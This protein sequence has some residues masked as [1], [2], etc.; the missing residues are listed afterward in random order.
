MAR[1]SGHYEAWEAHDGEEWWE[2]LSEMAHLTEES[3]LA[4][5]KRQYFGTAPQPC[6]EPPADVRLVFPRGAVFSCRASVV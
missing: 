1:G 6:S 3:L 5:L 2:D 4:E